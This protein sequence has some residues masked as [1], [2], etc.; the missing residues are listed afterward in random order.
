M[1]CLCLS[2]NAS[3]SQI[4]GIRTQARAASMAKKEATTLQR[5]L[6]LVSHKGT[7]GCDCHY[8]AIRHL[9]YTS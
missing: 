2:Q 4:N 1:Q 3:A 8:M 5:V 7:W 6:R 9:T